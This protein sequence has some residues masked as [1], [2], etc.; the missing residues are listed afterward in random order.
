M[1]TTST[2]VGEEVVQD[3][4]RIKLKTPARTSA[5][6]SRQAERPSTSPTID[7]M[8]TEARGHR[9]RCERLLEA[10]GAPVASCATT[11]S[12]TES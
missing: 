10:L 12:K 9:E 2:H 5:H 6:A 1:M 3:L 8:L 7:V 11:T 4:P